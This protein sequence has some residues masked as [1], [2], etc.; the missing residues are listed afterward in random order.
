MKIRLYKHKKVGKDYI[1]SKTHYAIKELLKNGEIIKYN[2]WLVVKNVFDELEEQEIKRIYKRKKKIYDAW[3]DAARNGGYLLED[4][5]RDYLNS[6][7]INVKKKSRRWRGR[8][9]KIDV[10]NPK[11][12]IEVKNV[13]S[14][15]FVNPEAIKKPNEDHKQIERLFKYCK[16]RGIKP[17]LIAPLIDNSFYYFVRKYNGLFC[18]SFIQVIPSCE[19]E[20]KQKIAKEFRIKNIRATNRLPKQIARWLDEN[21]LYVNSSKASEIKGLI[22]RN[23]AYAGSNGYVFMVSV[24]IFILLRNCLLLKGW[25][26]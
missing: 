7:G 14:D 16:S 1:W 12:A 3:N 13:F 9:I 18:R 24:Y 10:Y 22:G 26:D 17:I 4:M 15:E 2:G 5:V 25:S 19:S 11:F 8:K 23:R 6:K 20:L 21:L